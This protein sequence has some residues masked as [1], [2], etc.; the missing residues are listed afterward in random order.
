MFTIG[1]QVMNQQFFDVRF[2]TLG[3]L[4]KQH[5]KVLQHPITRQRLAW[6]FGL[7]TGPVDQVQ[8]T[9]VTQQVVQVQVFLPKA[10]G[11]HLRH[12]SQCLA[13]HL[14]LLVC[15]QRQVLHFGPGV[16][17]AEGTLKK[18]EQQPAALALAQA[19]CQKPRRGQPL[20][21]K[22]AHALQLTLKVPRSAVAHQQLGQYG[23]ATPDPGTDIA[24]PRQHPQQR[25]QLQIGSTGCIGQGNAQWQRRATSGALEFRQLHQRASLIQR[26]RVRRSNQLSTKALSA[27]CFR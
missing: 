12:R 9:V 16:G 3:Q 26:R 1:Q 21:G 19:I 22:Q 13:Q 4:R 6:G 5:P 27:G 8:L 23:L 20:P 24:L 2:K 17:Q 25:E 10:L 7:D 11:M 18:L 15:Q 14:L